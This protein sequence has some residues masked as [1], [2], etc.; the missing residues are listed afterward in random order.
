MKKNMNMLKS[1]ILLTCIISLL[2]V[3]MMVFAAN[4]KAPKINKFTVNNKDVSIGDTV[5][6]TWDVENATS[7]EIL[8]LEKE[9]EEELPLSGSLE[10]W[11]MATTTYVLI[12]K[13]SGG[14]VSASITVNVDCVGDVAIDY[15][16]AS[17]KNVVLGDTVTLSWSTSKA[18][19]VSI[20]GLEKTEEDELPLSGSIEAWPM[21]TTTYIL[22]AT[23][24]NGEVVSKAVTVNIVESLPAVINSFAASSEEIYEG[25]TVTLDWDVSDAVSVKL[26]GSEVASSG[27]LDVTPME[28][29]TYE[30]SAVGTDG[31]L[32]SKSITV[33][34]IFGPKI[35]SFTASATTVSKGKL[36]TLTWTTENA[37]E[38]VILT[39]DGIKLPNRPTNGK[40]SI[41]PNST[42]TF[43]LVAY[44]ENEVTDQ[45][46]ITITVK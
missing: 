32:V 6:L 42:K 8:G 13:G 18:C 2:S 7:I 43:T 5:I 15:F 24:C 35:T 12:A 33:T 22:Q 29:T 40:M 25:N 36:V 26:N 30:L 27:A 38:C 4:K 39:D 11:P 16:K 3:P 37:T 46:S 9:E 41:T 10:T 45:M 20:I 44:N 23:G 28:T 14:T 1:I 31:V 19:K 21:A 34:V 17:S